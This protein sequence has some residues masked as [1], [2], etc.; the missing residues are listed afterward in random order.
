MKI[1]VTSS[2]LYERVHREVGE[3]LDLADDLAKRLVRGGIASF[4]VR[5]L[6]AKDKVGAKTEQK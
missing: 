3:V 2:F 4:D 5:T 6:A 1:R